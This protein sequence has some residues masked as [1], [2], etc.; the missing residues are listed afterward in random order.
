LLA[1][2]SYLI[3]AFIIMLPLNGSC[4]PRDPGCYTFPRRLL[5]LLL[6]LIPIALSVYSINCMVVGKCMVWSWV[7]SLFIALWV[8]LF[9]IATVMSFDSR[10]SSMGPS[11]DAMAGE[12]IVIESS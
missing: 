7:N 3:M 9:L 11:M 4:D 1:A 8:L 6:M 2:V 12:I 5:V 10:D